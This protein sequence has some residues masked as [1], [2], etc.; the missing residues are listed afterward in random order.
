[1]PSSVAHAKFI[2]LKPTSKGP[3]KDEIGSLEFEFNPK[4]YTVKKAAKWETKESKGAKKAPMSEFKGAEPQTM[5]LELF[6]DATGAEK[7]INKD[8]ETMFGCCVPEKEAHAKNKPSP[9]FLR[10]EWG[11][12]HSPP[13]HLKSVSV[14]FTLFKPDGKPLRA[15]A[16]LELAEMA[17]EVHKQNPTSGALDVRTT[18]TVIAGDSLASIAYTE[19]GDPTRWRAIAITN[20]LSDPI[21]LVEG[22]RLLLPTPEEAVAVN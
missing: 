22:S 14:K 17:N 15:I 21:R 7:D 18:H 20:A 8:V 11:E 19:Y 12:F 4:E 2:I 9:P 6:L 5:S 16:S 13:M 1:M 3:P 10:F